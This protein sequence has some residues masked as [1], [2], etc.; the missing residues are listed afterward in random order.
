MSGILGMISD[1]W[2][3][4]RWCKPLKKRHWTLLAADAFSKCR[5]VSENCRFML[6]D[7]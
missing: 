3:L 5:E 4:D 1:L 2:G 7:A 6:Q